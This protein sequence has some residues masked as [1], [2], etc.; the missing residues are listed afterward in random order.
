VDPSTVVPTD[1]HY[2]T[3]EK[4]VLKP[5]KETAIENRSKRNRFAIDEQYR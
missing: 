5:D 2:K 3:M 4:K 1:E